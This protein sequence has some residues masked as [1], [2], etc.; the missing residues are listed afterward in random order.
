MVSQQG[1][2]HTQQ[3]TRRLQA[4]LNFIGFLAAGLLAASTASAH[5]WQ[6]GYEKGVWQASEPSQLNCELNHSIPDFGV[7]RFIHRSG[8]EVRM[9]IDTFRHSLREGWVELVALAPHWQPG[10]GTYNLGEYQVETT[11]Y[12]LKIG[13]RQTRLVLESLRQGR[14]PSLIQLADDERFERRRASM[15]P[16]R[17]HQA[18]AEFQRCQAQLL[19]VNYDQVGDIHINFPVGDNSLTAEHRELLDL[20]A[21]YVHADPEIESISIDGH[22]DSTGTRERNRELS[23]DRAHRVTNYL[24]ARGVP[25]DM[26]TTQFHGQRFPI[27]DNRTAAGR[28]QN[29]RVEVKLNRELDI[30][31][32]F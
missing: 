2:C 23:H 27:A 21:R 11:D 1:L 6:A 29:R 19:P 18:Y 9:E 7:V 13:T 26:I 31:P 20:L 12:P 30:R 8:D 4:P 14:M 5:T 10:L 17:F 28:D 24:V 16:I 15:T 3:P 32:L 22:S 25:A